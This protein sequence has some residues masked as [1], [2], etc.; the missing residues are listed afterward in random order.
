MHQVPANTVGDEQGFTLAETLAAIG[1]LGVGLV[2]L[3]SSM[4]WG[5]ASVDT[6]RRATTALFLA[7]QRMEQIKAVAVS[8]AA[9]Q[10]W[11]QV[12]ATTFPNEAYGAISGYRD[13]RRTVTI[14]TNP[15]GAANTKLVEVRVFYRPVTATGLGPETSVA[16]STLLVA[17]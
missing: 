6:S 1:I 8:T 13:Y 3:L 4:S 11:A 12:T 5:F 16:V 17:R 9:G 2:A 7:E 15:G 10:G 14:T